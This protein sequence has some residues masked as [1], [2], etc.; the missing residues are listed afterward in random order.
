[1]TV[2][3][4]RAYVLRIAPSGIDRM[5]EALQV[6]QVIVG[7]SDAAEL[8]DP[9][10]DWERFRDAVRTHYYSADSNLRRAGAAAGHMWRFI[11]GLSLGDLI[12]VPHS[13]SFYVARISGDVTH[14][15]AKVQTDTAFR[16]QVE[17]LNEKQ[18]IPRALARAALQSRLKIQG[19][20][21]DAT[22]L[23]DE[24]REC[25]DLA[26]RRETR[27]FDG[28]LRDRLT[29]EAL[30]EIRSG[31]L[32]SY[33]FENLLQSLLISLGAEEAR[34]VPRAEDKGADILAT[35]TLAGAIRLVVAVQAKHFQPEPPVGAAVIDQLIRGLEAES[36]NF[37]MV[38]TSGSFSD[39]AS[40]AAENYFDQKGIKIELVDG[41]QLAA[42]IV[43]QGLARKKRE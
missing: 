30:H 2:D 38:V 10:L 21:A 8:L 23:L 15:P 22:D 40:A 33:G 35:F 1:M 19:T 17:W 11:R 5:E 12:V 13:S 24:I 28:D 41:D 32:D 4:Q 37:G 39:G 31:R 3:A 27:T 34:I 18:A 9:A 7:W 36:A 29:R 20:S 14:D 16:R 25:L 43:E 26:G 6:G 42:M